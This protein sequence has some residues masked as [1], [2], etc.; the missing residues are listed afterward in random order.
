MYPF[1]QDP[2]RVPQWFQKFMLQY[3]SVAG[4]YVIEDRYQGGWVG[5]ASCSGERCS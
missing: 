4:V 1:L 3:Q 5:A 2:H